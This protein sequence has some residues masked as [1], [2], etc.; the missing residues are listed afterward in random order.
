METLLVVFCGGNVAAR[1]HLLY[2]PVAMGSLSMFFAFRLPRI[3]VIL[4][5]ASLSV[6]ACGEADQT[7]VR[8]A[9]SWMR[10]H[11]YD[12]QA[13]PI[14]KI[15]KLEIKDAENI[16]VEIL[17]PNEQH[18]DAIRAKSLILKSMIAKYACPPQTA[19]LWDIVKD[20]IQIRVNLHDHGDPLGSGIC[21]P[22]KR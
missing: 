6:S 9:V 3:L 21:Q 12:G 13:N 11:K 8:E 4:S 18:V 20:D 2:T 17:V 14:W 1:G 10:M 16:V 19:A 7:K 5:V 22:P 15:T